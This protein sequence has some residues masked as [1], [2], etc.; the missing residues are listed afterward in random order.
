MPDADI[1]QESEQQPDVYKPTSV[2]AGNVEANTNECI[3]YEPAG[4]DEQMHVDV[5]PEA[6][7][8]APTGGDAPPPPQ[9]HARDVQRVPLPL[10][11][12]K[13]PG[14][15]VAV[16][17]VLPTEVGI[18]ATR[19]CQETANA[20]IC[21]TIHFL[22]FPV[23]KLDREKFGHSLPMR[24]LPRPPPGWW[25]RATSWP[26][27]DP[28]LNYVLLPQKVLELTNT[29]TGPT[30]TSSGGRPRAL[31]EPHRCIAGAC[32]RRGKP[33]RQQHPRTTCTTGACESRG[34]PAW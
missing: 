8:Y 25:V 7:V 21:I 17:T 34:M 13:W 10:P 5:I 2:T 3:Q 28:D 1:S 4:G 16:R 9:P 23:Q 14:H 6:T 29:Q 22:H 20:N 31:L 12:W 15:E 27:D 19:A 26:L 32:C 11:S 33:G 30:R 24:R 18:I